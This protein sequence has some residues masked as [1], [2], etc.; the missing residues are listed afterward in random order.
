[1]Q[2]VGLVENFTYA[3]PNGGLYPLST[4]RI[5][6]SLLTPHANNIQPNI[7]PFLFRHCGG[8]LAAAMAAWRQWWRR[9]LGGGCST[10]A[11]AEAA[12]AW[13]RRQLS[14]S[15]VVV[16]AA[17][18]WQRWLR[19]Q[20]GG[21]AAGSAARSWWQR[22]H[23]VSTAQRRRWQRQ[24]RQPGGGGG[25]AAAA[26]RRRAAQRQ[27]WQRVRGG[28]SAVAERWRQHGNGGGSAA[29]AAASAC[30]RPRQLGVYAAVSIHILRTVV[31]DYGELTGLPYMVASRRTRVRDLSCSMILLQDLLRKT[32]IPPLVPA[33]GALVACL[34]GLVTLTSTRIY[35]LHYSTYTHVTGSVSIHILRTVVLDYGELLAY[36]FTL[37]RRQ[38]NLQ[39]TKSVGNNGIKNGDN[40]CNDDDDKN[41]DDGGGGG[42][43][44]AAWWQ[45]RR[46]RGGGGSVSAAA[47]ATAAAWQR[48]RQ[49]GRGG[50]GSLAGVA[51]AACA[52]CSTVASTH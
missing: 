4:P 11:A 32:L 24:G 10:A 6:N 34:T 38:H 40:D 21:S 31:L 45:W 22:Q 39:S 12:A 49:L 43:L 15:L 48:R 33:R 46:K 17:A 16:A 42:S 30:W 41:E 8:S 3:P 44:A 7:L 50:S 9:Q 13:Q 1:L 51:V 26:R 19:W 25:S 47:V 29:A 35:D 2:L 20:L 18:A 28:G 5:K 27:H 36:W 37:Q 23:Y 14:G 52:I